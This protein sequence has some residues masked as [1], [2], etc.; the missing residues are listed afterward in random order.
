INGR[1]EGGT[2]SSLSIRKRLLYP[3]SLSLHT[4]K[5][6]YI[7]PAMKF[8]ATILVAVSSLVAMASAQ[9]LQ[10]NNPTQGSVWTTNS[11]GYL[12]WSGNC[13]NMGNAGRNVTVDI[14]TG[15]ASAVRYVATLGHINCRSPIDHKTFIV[16]TI[17]SGTYALIV[18]TTP[19]PSLTNFFEIKRR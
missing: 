15:T 7:I 4:H 19:R 14:V 1:K 6:T 17:E 13:K 18:R 5:D 11:E 8:L 16:P 2:I 12:A 10:I 3:H 9:P